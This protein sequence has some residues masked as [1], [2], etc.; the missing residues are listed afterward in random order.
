[1]L[2]EAEQAFR[3][4]LDGANLTR[5]KLGAS[6]ALLTSKRTEYLTRGQHAL[7]LQWLKR[8]TDRLRERPADTKE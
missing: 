1:M 5:Q 7:Y 3:A 6:M 2:L 4:A 8:Q